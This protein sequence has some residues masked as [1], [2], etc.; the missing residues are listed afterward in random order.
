MGSMDHGFFEGESS[1]SSEMIIG[2]V[3]W[4][5]GGETYFTAGYDIAS[6]RHGKIHDVEER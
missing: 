1:N 5:S 3:A 2:I 6:N 4:E